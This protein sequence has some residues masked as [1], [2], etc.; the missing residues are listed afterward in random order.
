MG[1]IPSNGALGASS[2]SASA[3]I[4]T[5]PQ[6]FEQTL[7]NQQEHE[8]ANLLNETTIGLEGAFQAQTS[9]QIVAGQI[10]SGPNNLTLQQNRQEQSVAQ[11]QRQQQQQSAAKQWQQQTQRSCG[12]NKQTPQLPTAKAS[13]SS[14]SSSSSPSRQIGLQHFNYNPLYMEIA[15]E[16][17]QANNKSLRINHNNT[18]QRRQING[19]NYL[20]C[21]EASSEVDLDD[22]DADEDILSNIYSYSD[23]LVG[24][25]AASQDGQKTSQT[26]GF[27][28]TSNNNSH[29][30][31]TPNQIATTKCSDQLNIETNHYQTALENSELC[32]QQQS[33]QQQFQ[34]PSA[35]TKTQL[36]YQNENNPV[37][38]STSCNNVTR[39]RGGGGVNVRQSDA[40]HS[41]RRPTSKTTGGITLTPTSSSSSYESSYITSTSSPS[42]SSLAAQNHHQQVFHVQQQQQQQLDLL[43][44]CGG[45]GGGGLFVEYQNN[46]NSLEGLEELHSLNVTNC[47][48]DTLEEHMNHMLS[49]SE[50][51]FGVGEDYQDFGMNGAHDN[52]ADMFIMNTSTN[53]H[54][55]HQQ[56]VPAAASQPMQPQQQVGASQMLAGQTNNSVQQTDNMIQQQQKQTSQ[57]SSSDQTKMDHMNRPIQMIVNGQTS[58][59]RKE[60]TKTKTRDEITPETTA[61]ALASK[62]ASNTQTHCGSTPRLQTNNKK[63]V[64]NKRKVNCGGT[65]ARNTNSNTKNS[66]GKQQQLQEKTPNLENLNNNPNRRL[67]STNKKSSTNLQRQQQQ[68]TSATKTFEKTNSWMV[69][70]SSSSTT[71]NISNSSV[72]SPSSV[73]QIEYETPYKQQLDNL[74]KKLK[75][76]VMPNQVDKNRVVSTK[77]EEHLSHQTNLSNSTASQQQ[78]RVAATGH[79][80]TSGIVETA[81]NSYFVQPTSQRQ[82]FEQADQQQRDDN[83]RSTFYLKT[84]NGLVPINSS[85]NQPPRTSSGMHLL[86]LANTGDQNHIACLAPSQT[87]VL[88]NHSQL[89]TIN[90]VSSG[91]YEQPILAANLTSEQMQLVAASSS[92]TLVQANP[93]EWQ[94]SPGKQQPTRRQHD[95]VQIMDNR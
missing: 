53:Q 19:D 88:N 89:I 21:N 67:L 11:Q 77:S 6:A 31:H 44:E 16:H 50:D 17:Q 86:S 90:C 22:E 70:P 54:S 68:A 59:L 8:S 29:I 45:G 60:M 92:G 56:L 41:I 81:S 42:S 79:D 1:T 49:N 34:Q 95:Y 58:Q 65:A 69:S 39:Q 13:S 63:L 66:G 83:N 30:D 3:V 25:R 38:S 91:H 35:A 15:P 12:Q 5:S 84:P 85:P 55:H 93:S 73:M 46:R 37:G 47:D 4:V 24:G 32:A 52:F 74:R 36:N 23:N 48:S 61:T 2:S 82:S 71:S 9:T 26:V 76:D 62:K 80:E 72:L 75:M 57:F 28:P 7:Q 78:I 33:D 40:C 20:N 51:C 43:E 27:S 10:N 87:S 64:N 18:N 94:V 14:S